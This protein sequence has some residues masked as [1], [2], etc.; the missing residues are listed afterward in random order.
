MVELLASKGA[1]FF[2]VFVLWGVFAFLVA[3][4]LRALGPLGSELRRAEVLALVLCTALVLV[5][6]S[7]VLVLP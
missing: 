4:Y 3:R 5:L 7:L 6:G 1:R 2:V